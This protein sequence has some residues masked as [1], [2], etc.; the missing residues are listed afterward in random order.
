MNTAPETAVIFINFK[1]CPRAPSGIKQ[2]I[3]PTRRAGYWPGR[4]EE[5][6]T[7]KSAQTPAP[8]GIYYLKGESHSHLLFSVSSLT[9]KWRHK[10]SHAVWWYRKVPHFS[11][12]T[13]S[14]PQRWDRTSIPTDS[15]PAQPTLERDLTDTEPNPRS[16][17]L[18]AQ[19]QQTVKLSHYLFSFA[20]PNHPQRFRSNKTISIQNTFLGTFIKCCRSWQQ[21][22]NRIIES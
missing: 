21:V 16:L 5:L 11:S 22:K 7:G 14:S 19:K 8:R 1:L 2:T 20:T 15:T 13:C 18:S 10:T 17:T 6:E 12:N 3:E 9:F 4:N